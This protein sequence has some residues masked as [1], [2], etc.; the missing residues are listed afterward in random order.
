MHSSIA[1][2]TGSCVIV[3]ISA[4]RPLQ[5][6]QSGTVRG[7]RPLDATAEGRD[8][9]G[10]RSVAVDTDRRVRQ[11]V[12]RSTGP[13]ALAFALALA[14]PGAAAELIVDSFADS[15]DA[16]PGDGICADE[17]GACS[18]RAALGEADLLEGIDRILLAEGEHALTATIEVLS[19]VELAPLDPAGAPPSIRGSVRFAGPADLEGLVFSDLSLGGLTELRS[20]DVTDGVGMTIEPG[21]TVRALQCRVHDNDPERGTALLVEGVLRMERCEITGN[22]SLWNP[23]GSLTVRGAGCRVQPGASLT[24]I[25]CL[26]AWN[27]SHAVSITLGGSSSG[28][29]AG[30]YADHANVR[31]DACSFS[32]NKAG[33]G[34]AYTR[35]ASGAGAAIFVSGGTLTL[36]RSTFSRNWLVST[37]LSEG[38][39]LHAGRGARVLVQDCTFAEGA[40][41]NPDGYDEAADIGS[42]QSQVLVRNTLFTRWLGA[43]E[44]DEWTARTHVVRL[45]PIERDGLPAYQPTPDS[46]ALDAGGG[47][48]F[49]D[50]F[51]GLRPIGAACDVGAIEACDD[52]A[53]SDGDGLGDACDPC[54][55]LDGDAGLDGDGDGLADACDPCPGL[56]SGELDSDGDGVG[57]ACDACVLDAGIGAAYASLRV[58]RD[59]TGGQLLSWD[60]GASGD[61]AVLA[62]EL[63]TLSSYDH[64]ALDC[65]AAA[66]SLTANE[67]GDVWFALRFDCP[68]GPSTLGWNSTA[69]SRPGTAACP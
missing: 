51:G 32:R 2:V 44:V 60:V 62:G 7:P 23:A 10:G 43:V 3:A 37:T 68:S 52:P 18:L 15:V 64:V 16:V 22:G 35:L 27:T 34:S 38:V 66:G 53:D 4:R 30:I 13:A 17:T 11:R 55:L 20:V 48:S 31:V 56:P 26:V 59:D 9:P 28:Y 54:P 19:A 57:D 29:G 21:A 69:A 50:Q 49:T 39:H 6:A 42:G 45:T 33:G 47:C 46:E 5:R 58:A 65:L 25:R 67:P 8:V 24:L 12:N 40:N 41:S 63:A 36:T 61:V 14:S 1:L